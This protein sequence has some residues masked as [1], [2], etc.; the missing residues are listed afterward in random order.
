MLSLIARLFYIQLIDHS[1]FLESENNVLRRIIV[2]PAR[3]VVL[4]RTGKILVEN[5]PVYD[6]L[7]TPKEVKEFDTISLCNLLGVDK[8]EFEQRFEE[9]KDNSPRKPFIIEKQLSTETYAR[10]QERM[11][12]YKGFYVENRTVRSYPKAI[13]AQVLGYVGEVDDKIIKKQNGFYK[14]G[15][16]IGLSGLE[17]SYEPILRGQRGVRNVLYDVHN[18]E[19]GSYENGKYDTLAVSGEKL[20]SSINAD[21]Q[22][23]GEKLMQ[24]KLGSI[25]C[26]EPK[27]GE[28]L[29]L[30]SSP[31]YDP[32][33]LVGRERG[34]N[35]SKLYVDPYIPLYMRPLQAYYP[36]G[37]TIKPVQ[38]LIGE[39]EKLI[40]P[41]TVFPGGVGYWAGSHLVK[42][43]HS[44]PPLDL[45][46]AIEES[47]NSYFCHVFHEVVERGI[48]K[49][50]SGNFQEWRR[51][52]GNFGFGGTLGIDIPNEKR[53]RL[54]TPAGYNK[55]YGE[56]HWSSNTIIS[57]AIGQGELDVT[58]LQM[59]NEMATIA[60]KGFYYVPH[61]VK[62]I[63]K[64]EIIKE[65][66]TKKHEVGIDSAYFDIVMEGMQ[67]V[68]EHG[69]AQAAKIKG[70]NICAKTGTAENTH[71]EDH[72]VFV[73]FAP[74][75]NPRIAIS[76]I[77][78]NGGQGAHWAAPIASLMIEKY[79]RDSISRPAYE[80]RMLE[81][82]V[83]PPVDNRGHPIP[84]EYFKKRDSLKLLI[85][86]TN[87]GNNINF[88]KESFNKKD[89][90]KPVNNH[91]KIKPAGKLKLAKN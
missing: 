15:D 65:I 78:E 80:K 66:F 29:A 53:G 72:S 79:L 32:N 34:H 73:A 24:N 47:S 87:S 9:A 70:I 82:S 36:P 67:L 28:I 11:F 39:S 88:K 46:G 40:Y 25:V 31:T 10:L 57:L 52:M 18:V 75:E 83:L 33:L 58:P 12:S 48:G 84:K 60:N 69:T 89:S 14:Q 3:G 51:Y 43:F 7:V 16:Y 23:Y 68:V 22:S 5:I 91:A 71:G 74:R 59:A 49:G 8:T 27:T 50:V 37:S 30:I 85:T 81:G 41:S 55:V 86:H 2:Y 45:K 17:G 20:I 77:V 4:D 62:A 61:L 6:L 64:K 56:G 76:V 35:F 26:I 1:Y 38:A 90:V 13:A 19:K 44:L 63:G 54:P 42:N 21:L